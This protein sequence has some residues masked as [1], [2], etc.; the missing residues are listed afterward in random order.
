MNKPYVVGFKDRVEVAPDV[1]FN[2]GTAHK[3][4]ADENEYLV[5]HCKA[6]IYNLNIKPLVLNIHAAITDAFRSHNAAG[7]N[8]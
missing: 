8:R 6:N 3:F 4:T 5:A 7:A 2:K 1:V